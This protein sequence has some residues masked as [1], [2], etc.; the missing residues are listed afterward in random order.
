M[1]QEKTT[2]TRR[3]S[4]Q[5][6]DSK[7]LKLSEGSLNPTENE[8]SGKVRVLTQLQKTTT[9]KCEILL[10]QGIPPHKLINHLPKI[11]NLLNVIADKEI[12]TLCYSLT[13]SNKGAT[14]NPPGQNV[15]SKGIDGFSNSRIQKLIEALKQQNY[16]PN[17]VTQIMIP[18]PGKKVKRPL[19]LPTYDDKV[20]QEAIRLTLNAIYDPI[21]EFIDCNHGFRPNHSPH[22]ALHH[23]QYKIQGLPLAIEGDIQGAYN[24]LDHQKLLEIL[25]KR[26]SDKKYLSLIE[27]YLKSG[28]FNMETKSFENTILGVP[29]G[30]IASPILFNIYMHEF[31]CFI[32]ETIQTTHQNELNKSRPRIIRE[33]HF[34]KDGRYRSER[35]QNTESPLHQRLRNRMNERKKKLAIQLSNSTLPITKWTTHDFER[36]KSIKNEIKPLVKTLNKITYSNLATNPIRSLYIRFADD[37]VFFTNTTEETAQT[38]KSKIANF[39]LE[40]LKMTLSPDKTKITNTNKEAAKFLGFEIV[41]IKN[42]FKIN[43][44]MD[45]VLQ[46]LKLKGFCDEKGFPRERPAYSILNEKSIIDHSNSTILGVCNYY[47]P[48]ITTASQLNRIGYIIQY[49]C[50]KTL[51]QKLKTTLPKVI[52]KMKGLK[53]NAY[54]I[55]IENETTEHKIHNYISCRENFPNLN[56]ARKNYKYESPKNTTYNTRMN[57]AIINHQQISWR[58]KKSLLYAKCI[59]CGTTQNISSHHIHSIRS[60]QTQLKTR[61]EDK[62]PNFQVVMRALNRKQVPLCEQHHLEVTTSRTKL[63]YMESI[64]TLY[65]KR[66]NPNSNS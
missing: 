38:I 37:W 25:S 11:D 32:R 3:S 4:K 26:I 16:T 10:K 41:Q 23:L 54:P 29:Q 50:L 52:H 56:I 1:S 48:V 9:E 6:I 45:R 59:V 2:K 61:K 55:T 7:L 31:D 33:A 57:E 14:T 36:R 21:F 46:R 28:L 20:V 65:E 12:L 58:T 15:K 42:Y 51:A 19:G 53:N 63:P 8:P 44:D 66:I 47:Y 30:Q 43:I 39:L 13:R 22:T 60:L 34:T 5:S 35:L 24:S 49:S 27:K 17:P 62:T 40:E 18:K 64:N